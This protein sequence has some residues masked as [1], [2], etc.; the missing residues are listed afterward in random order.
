VITQLTLRNFKSVGD[1]LYKFTNFDLLVGRNNS[2]KSTVLQSL[3]IWQFCMDEFHRTKR[4]GNTGIQIVLPNFTALPVPEFNLL[5]KDRTDRAYPTDETGAKKQKFILIEILLEWSAPG[6][7][8][9]AFGVELRYHSPQTMYAIPAGGWKAFRD[10]EEKGKLP[11]IAYVP[12]FSGLEPAEKWL[13]KAPIRQQ[14][15]KGQP[16]SVLRNLLLQVWR[17]PAEDEGALEQ[18]K[19]TKRPP[20][21]ADWTELASVVKRWFSIELI[22]PQYDSA[23]DVYIGVEYKQ[24][25]KTYDLISGGSGFHQT[26]TLLAFLYGYQ[27]TT[28]LLDEPDAHLHVNLQR[29]ILD[30]FKKKAAEKG[31]QFLIATH[32]EEF[33]KGVDAHQILSLLKQVPTRIE[34]TPAILRAMSEVSNEDIARLAGAPYMVYVEGESDER[35]LRGWAEQC[36]ALPVMDKLCFKVMGGGNKQAM[37]DQADAH[38]TALSQIVPG[39]KRLML[40]DY[41]DADKAFHPPEGNPALVE[42]KRKN[43]ENYL[44]VPPAWQRVALQSLNNLDG[45]LFNQPVLQAID[46]FFADQNLTLAPGKTWRTVTANIFAVLDGKR[47]LFE[48][49]DSLFHT[50]RRGE[51]SVEV[52]RERVATAMTADEIHEDVHRFFAKLM[53]MTGTGG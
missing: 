2:G 28:I 6:G 48:N 40:F 7:T 31:V 33:A 43:I 27:P 21:P 18:A 4:S 20:V 47:I 35:I 11:R 39:V 22:P 34:S 44:L 3:A 41:D 26:M 24:N 16:G 15:G 1:Q 30:Y 29:E 8:T 50:L 36:G 13:D 19:P 52:L 46:V 14:V 45:D 12:P 53:A 9:Q 5:W 38:F 49:N 25:G 17:P 10:C 32:A 23:K 51:P 42:W 37:K